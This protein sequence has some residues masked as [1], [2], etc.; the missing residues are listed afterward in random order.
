M[1]KL[2]VGII[3]VLILGGIIYFVATS[4]RSTE[5]AGGPVEET[6]TELP[7]ATG[8]VDDATTLILQDATGD[9]PGVG[10]NDPETI[11]ENQEVDDFGQSLGTPE[12]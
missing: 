9:E 4:P 10:E 3:V 5:E 11:L 1:G 7:A 6:P 8:N 12:L 2:I